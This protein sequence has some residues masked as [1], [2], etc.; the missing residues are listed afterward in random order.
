MNVLHANID[1]KFTELIRRTLD[2]LEN[3]NAMSKR[4]D[5]WLAKLE[6]NKPNFLKKI[7]IR[8]Y[9]NIDFSIK[10]IKTKLGN[11]PSF[12]EIS[13]FISKQSFWTL[14]FAFGIVCWPWMDK[15]AFAHCWAEQLCLP[16][17]INETEKLKTL[18]DKEE[19]LEKII[20]LSKGY[21]LFK[22]QSIF[23]ILKD[24]KSYIVITFVRLE[25]INQKIEESLNESNV[26][27][28]STP[29]NG[30]FGKMSSK[31]EV[32]LKTGSA[33]TLSA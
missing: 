14:L 11:T 12:N 30:L 15:T 3:I 20:I 10:K 19:F 27:P 33:I 28:L 22:N 32:N 21:F 8:G 17:I 16:E 26:P 2:E 18:D 7:L 29:I 6:S 5:Y 24:F 13:N 31:P 4:K 9:F 25:S 23:Q 1:E